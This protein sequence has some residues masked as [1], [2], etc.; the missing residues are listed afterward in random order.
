MSDEI[1][2]ANDA[3]VKLVMHSTNMTGSR[4]MDFYL[5]SNIA[6][7]LIKDTNKKDPD[8]KFLSWNEKADIYLNNTSTLTRAKNAVTYSLGAGSFEFEFKGHKATCEISVATDSYISKPFLEHDMS[9]NKYIKI[10]FHDSK[11]NEIINEI[12]KNA[13][14]YVDKNILECD[15]GDGSIKIYTN[16]DG[17]WEKALSKRKRRL[18]TIYLPKADKQAILK[19]IEHFLLPSTADRYESI[20]RTHKRVYLFEGLPGAGKSSFILALASYF[21]YDLA[22]ISF[23]EKVTDGTLI[24]LLKNLPEK[25][26]LVMEDIDV[27]F[28]DRKKNDEHKNM[29]TFSGILNNLDGITTQDGFICFITTNYKDLLDSALLR[30]GRIDKQLKFDNANKEQIQDMFIKF[31]GDLYS[32]DKFKEFY[33]GFTKLGINTTISLIQEYLFKYIDSPDAAISNIDELKTIYEAS[34]KKEAGLYT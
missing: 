32:E 14:N 3:S 15:D 20:G 19:D 24:K 7:F 26:I 34:N 29:V 12:F 16:D 2:I 4:R 5:A 10:K 11:N 33:R 6:Q 28:N 17:Y 30:P 23:T 31:M 21:D 27:L 1:S 13:N 9:F 18:D 22:V 25:T 8:F